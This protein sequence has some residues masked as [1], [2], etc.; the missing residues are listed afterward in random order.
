MFAFSD[1]QPAV[2]A[3]F[4]L[5]PEQIRS[6]YGVKQYKNAGGQSTGNPWQ[7]TGFYTYE[8]RKNR[9]VLEALYVE[10]A[11]TCV[12]R[13]FRERRL[14][15]FYAKKVVDE[16]DNLAQIIQEAVLVFQSQLPR[17]PI[18]K[19]EPDMSAFGDI[20]QSIEHLLLPAPPPVRL[21]EL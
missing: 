4:Q 12:V 3:G 8:S 9:L 15:V 6:N 19:D 18:K 17:K 13:V 2:A 1:I 21:S 5:L 11:T 10:T 16:L 20:A 14:K 7:T